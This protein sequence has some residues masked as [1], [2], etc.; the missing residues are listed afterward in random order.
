MENFKCG[1][2]YM[3]NARGT[4][5]YKIGMTTSFGL[6]E[7]VKSNSTGCP[8]PLDI[9]MAFPV[10]DAPPVERRIHRAMSGYRTRGEWFKL[11]GTGL[12]LVM[13]EFQKD[14]LDFGMSLII[15]AD[16]PLCI[17]DSPGDS[18]S[19]DVEISDRVSPSLTRRH[20]NPAA[21][22]SDDVAPVGDGYP[23]KKEFKFVSAGTT[24]NV[25]TARME[26]IISYVSVNSDLLHKAPGRG[27]LVKIQSFV[28]S[29]IGET[30]G[31]PYVSEVLKG[32]REGHLI[33]KRYGDEAINEQ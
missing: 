6:V 13:M 3:M 24:A 32:I 33:V 26:A 17:E 10:R 21:A 31:K 12:R 1:C 18:Y 4:N 22:R 8:Y 25:P 20:P 16:I 27:E 23:T 2:I 11:D 14:I 29:R 19:M 15:E 30:I 28:E 7:R 9:I 5:L